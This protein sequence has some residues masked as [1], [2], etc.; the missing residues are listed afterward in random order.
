MTIDINPT[1]VNVVL[2]IGLTIAV[3]VVGAWLARF[4]RRRLRAAIKRAP[5]STSVA[6]LLVTVAYYSVWVLTASVALI[7]LGFP[8][9]TVVA[10]LAIVVIILGIAMQ[11]SL[12][13]FAAAV[14]FRLFRSFE[15][16]EFIQV[17]QVM[18]TVQEL[19]PFSTTLL[20]A[21][22]KIVQIA[23]S[24]LQT[25][26]MTNFS[27]A[28]FLRPLLT[29]GVSY[30]SDLSVVRRILDETAQA[31][32]NVLK[33]PPPLILVNGLGESDIQVGLRVSCTLANYWTVQSDLREQV[34]ARFDEAGIVMWVPQLMVREGSVPAP[35]GSKPDTPP[36]SKEDEHAPVSR[37]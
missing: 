36:E 9:S 2:H 8:A 14:N 16:G 32:P 3:F 11:Q 35:V 26:G 28:E 33:D 24:E 37:K 27:R 12:K 23:N 17:N 4:T 30:A 29:F 15:P 18:G 1:L 5:V 13:D 10:V 31:H 22:N 20:T 25:M 7:T 6:S 21:E 19:L 34:K